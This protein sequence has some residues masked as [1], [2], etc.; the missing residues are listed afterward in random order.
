MFTTELEKLKK[1]AKSAT[2]GSWWVDS[3][4]QAVVSFHR[5]GDISTIFITDSK[6]MGP[7]RRHEDTGNLSHWD[8]DNDATFI[9]SFDPETAIKLIEALEQERK[10]S[11]FLR[12]KIRELQGGS[13]EEA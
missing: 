4:G 3:H 9:A 12:E 11:A 10:K 13:D 6:Q 1:I 5:G 2:Q 7:A 8:N